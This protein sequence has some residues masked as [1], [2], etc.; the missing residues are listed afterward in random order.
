MMTWQVRMPMVRLLSLI[1]PEAEAEDLFRPTFRRTA[2]SS[3]AAKAG[4]I[5]G[6]FAKSNMQSVACRAMVPAGADGGGKRL[7]S[8]RCLTT[9]SRQSYATPC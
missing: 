1:M 2:T 8:V 9:A 3:S 7:C 4:G 5:R 6:F